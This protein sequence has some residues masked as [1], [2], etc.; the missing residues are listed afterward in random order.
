M[1]AEANY[2][3]TNLCHAVQYIRGRLISTPLLIRGLV[4]PTVT[5]IADIDKVILSKRV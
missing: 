2:Q 5:Y 1:F 4:N 3:A